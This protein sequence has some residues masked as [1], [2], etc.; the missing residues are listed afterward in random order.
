MWC[1]ALGTTQI[2]ANA[3]LLALVATDSEAAVVLELSPVTGTQ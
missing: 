3:P 2:T 1:I